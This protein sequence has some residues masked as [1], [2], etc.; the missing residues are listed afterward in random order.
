MHQTAQ[1]IRS[2]L[3]EGRPVAVGRVVAIQGFSTWPGD[4][5]L[6]V[7]ADGATA[8]SILGAAGTDQLRGAAVEMLASGDAQRTVTVEIHGKAVIEAGLSCGGQAT[9]RLQPAAAFPAALWS[10]L[11]ARAPVALVTEPD[12]GMSVVSAPAPGGGPAQDEAASSEPLR[13]GASVLASGHSS[14][15]SIDTP[16]GAVLVEAWISPPRVVVVGNG[17]LVPALAAQAALLGWDT[18][19]VENPEGL[20]AALDWAGTTAALVVLSHDP[21]VDVPALRIGLE[22]EVPYVG[23]MG[24]RRTQSRRIDRLQESGVDPDLLERIHRPVGLDL[25]GRSAPEVA[26]AICAEILAER[27]GSDGRS[28]RDRTGPIH[29]QPRAQ[30]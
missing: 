25:G 22:R 10:A 15:Q 5:L 30:R 9:V 20:D 3:D 21:H 23:A 19:A 24:S 13:L 29:D 12:G 28:L 8:G 7:D 11:A 18:R 17:D 14:T 27:T 16:A 2:W 26:L 4:E 6:A 1:Q